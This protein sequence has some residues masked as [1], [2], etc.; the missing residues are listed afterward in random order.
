MPRKELIYD[1]GHYYRESEAQQSERQKSTGESAHQPRS[2]GVWE[3]TYKVWDGVLYGIGSAYYKVRGHW[4]NG[5]ASIHKSKRQW[6]Q[7]YND[8]NN[9]QQRWKMLKQRMASTYDP[10]Y[11][12]LRTPPSS[13]IVLVN[14]MRL[15]I[16]CCDWYTVHPVYLAETMEEDIRIGSLFWWSSRS[17]VVI[18]GKD[19]QVKE[20]ILRVWQFII[21]VSEH[22]TT[23]GRGQESQWFGMSERHGLKEMR[24]RK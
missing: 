1:D 3:K 17:G 18:E 10:L 9:E 5:N 19:K 14:S 6:R 7:H 4:G 11:K 8:W 23:D 21:S 15:Y 2:G 24:D 20:R 16:V 12:G 13:L 22:S